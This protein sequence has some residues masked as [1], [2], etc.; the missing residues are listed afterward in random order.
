MIEVTGL[1]AAVTAEPAL[2]MAELAAEVL[3]PPEEWP[4]LERR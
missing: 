2:V 4:P 3:E 1:D